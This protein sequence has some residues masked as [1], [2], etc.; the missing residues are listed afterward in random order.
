MTMHD[1]ARPALREPGAA[2]RS[3][4]RRSTVVVLH[5]PNGGSAED[6]AFLQPVLARA[7]DV[8]MVEIP[9]AS[10]RHVVEWNTA[11]ADAGDDVTA[12]AI[13][14]HY[15]EAIRASRTTAH[16]VRIAVIDPEITGDEHDAGRTPVLLLVSGERLG[17]VRQTLAERPALILSLIE[18]FIDGRPEADTDTGA[19]ADTGP[20]AGTDTDTPELRRPRDATRT[21]IAATGIRDA[22]DATRPAALTEIDTV[23]VGA[24][25][26]GLG[27]GIRL[28][29]RGDASFVILERAGDVGG[30]WR[31]NVYPGV[32]CDIPAHLYAFSFL[33]NPN[34]SSF[35]ASG[36]E[37]HTYLQDAVRSEGL[38]PHLRLG[39]DVRDLRWRAD[40]SRWHV[41]T[42]SGDYLCRTLIVAAGRLSDSRMPEVP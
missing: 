34:W 39:V 17:D 11:L 16:L 33:P 29:R 19:E 6:F 27:A 7:R 41:S 35:F 32:A 26:A 42:S 40:D 38:R 20:E 9:D 22:T 31:D 1:V 10:S 15:D 14:G 30:T 37:I 36:R 4:P 23:I 8:L 2:S 21:H 18:D 13:G 5:G 24:G 12:L 25:F 3:S 28:A